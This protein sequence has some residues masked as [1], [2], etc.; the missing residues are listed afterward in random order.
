MPYMPLLSLQK[1]CL[2]NKTFA[3]N[4]NSGISL[5]YLPAFIP[6]YNVWVQPHLEYAMQVRA[7]ILIIDVDCR[8]HPAVDDDPVKDFPV[9]HRTKGNVGRACAPLIRVTF[10]ETLKRFI[11][12]ST[13][14]WV[15]TPISS[16]A[17]VLR[18]AQSRVQISK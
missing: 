11:K 13:D 15:L 6:F 2:Q 1:C 5:N 17:S 12:C 16:S 8:A 10:M 9:C 4:E 3:V 14:D 7:L 18:F